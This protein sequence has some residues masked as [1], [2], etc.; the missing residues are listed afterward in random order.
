MSVFILTYIFSSFFAYL[1]S[2]EK[3]KYIASLLKICLFT[4]LFLPLALRYDI[5]TDYVN[6]AQ[7][8]TYDV[9]PV[10]NK[11]GGFEFGWR[12][13]LW[14]IKTFEIDVHYFFVIIAF[15][16]VLLVL[17]IV[18]KK[19]AYFAIV[20]YVSTLYL[21]SFSL[22]RQAFAGLIAFYGIASYYKKDNK[23]YLIFVFAACLFHSSMY[24]FLVLLPVFLFMENV[25][26]FSKKKI[27]FLFS[28]IYVFFT[29][30]NIPKIVFSVIVNSVFSSMS[31]YFTDELYGSAT[32]LG[33]GLGVLLKEFTAFP[34]IFFITYCN[35]RKQTNKF[36]MQALIIHFLIIITYIFST[37]I[38]ILNRLPYI[39]TPYFLISINFLGNSKSKYRKIILI[40]VV[41]I[42]TTNF[43]VNLIKNPSASP[44]GLGITP[45]Q[46]IF[47]R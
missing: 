1:Y 46:S 16:S 18:E 20:I 30:I 2:V 11:W 43:I 27:I 25:Q 34:F 13:L 5:G 40:L 12:P 37:Q 33:T 35:K 6:Y 31:R 8:I 24:F 45:Y 28:F 44:G 42:F 36:F 23:R 4:S 38:T 26:P 21:D 47:S 3:D 7:Q 9:N 19:Y 15:F 41:I 14:L 39:F 32:K 10:E 17:N 29:V 22:V